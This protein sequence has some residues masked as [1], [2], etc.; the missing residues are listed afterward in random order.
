MKKKEN[1]W[2]TSSFIELINDRQA[3][4]RGVQCERHLQIVII[5]RGEEIKTCPAQ[6]N[7][8]TF[9]SVNV[10]FR[11]LNIPWYFYNFLVVKILVI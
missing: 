3:Q 7:R 1:T 10:L 11:Q 9:T 8:S 6:R 5:A 2:L 4:Y